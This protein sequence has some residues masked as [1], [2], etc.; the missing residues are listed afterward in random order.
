MKVILGNLILKDADMNIGISF[1]QEGILIKQ[2]I[3]EAHD[4]SHSTVNCVS[5]VGPST[6]HIPVLLWR[7]DARRTC[8]RMGPVRLR[9]VVAQLETVAEPWA[10]F[11]ICKQSPPTSAPFS[12]P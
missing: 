12:Q 11:V 8:Q 7:L 6:L 10:H 1:T 2:N 3:F 5:Q 9:I 4:F